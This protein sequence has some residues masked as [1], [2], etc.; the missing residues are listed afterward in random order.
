MGCSRGI[1]TPEKIFIYINIAFAMYSGALLAT[2]AR[3]AWDPSTYTWFRFLCSAQYVASM[4]YVL[5]AGLWLAALVYLAAAAVHHH[6]RKCL[7]VYCAGVVCLLLSEVIYG[8]WM[9][10][11]LAVWWREAPEAEFTRRAMDVVH[12]LKPALLAMERYRDLVRPIY[13]MIEEMERRAPSNAYVIIVFGVIGLFLQ[14]AA[15]V[16]AWRLAQGAG[17]CDGTEACCKERCQE[18]PLEECCDADEGERPHPP[19]W[20]KKANLRM[21]TI[22]DKIF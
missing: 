14:V 1:C 19:G 22:L 2:G 8:A 10:A 3:L 18:A 5:V 16:M 13:D 12:D 21:Y 6:R 9:G 4:A 11:S 7:L 15:L 17:E 20:R